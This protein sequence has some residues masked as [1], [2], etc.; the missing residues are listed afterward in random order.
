MYENTYTLRL[1]WPLRTLTYIHTYMPA[2]VLELS[3]VFF[4][5]L[6]AEN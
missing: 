5:V 6:R 4:S 3:V 2:N 1:L